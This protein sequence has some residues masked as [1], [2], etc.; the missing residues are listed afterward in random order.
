MHISCRSP[1]QCPVRVLV[2]RA[3][4][5]VMRFFAENAEAV[6]AMKNNNAESKCAKLL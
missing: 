1:G 6:A 5:T 3:L 2:Q 4:D